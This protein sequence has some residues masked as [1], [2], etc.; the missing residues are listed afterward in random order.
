ME[1][2]AWSQQDTTEN[3]RLLGSRSPMPWDSVASEMEVTAS[4]SRLIRSFRRDHAWGARHGA[5]SSK[6]SINAR[7]HQILALTLT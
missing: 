1:G 7:G 5:G 2:R 4:A 6:C 3:P